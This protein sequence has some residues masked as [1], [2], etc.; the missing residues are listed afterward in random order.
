MAASL[1]LAGELYSYQDKV[2]RVISTSRATDEVI[3]E[4]TANG[5]Q[6]KVRFSVFQYAYQRVWKIGDAASFIGRHPRSLYRYEAQGVIGKPMT[7]RD[8]AGRQ[9]RYYS[10]EDIV[11][12][13]QHVSEVHQGRPRQDGRAVNNTMPNKYELLTMF[14]ERFGL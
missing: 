4:D 2:W 3:L 8:K 6:Y 14:R 12:M 11:E 13:H 10:K 5:D 1:P 7:Y 9:V